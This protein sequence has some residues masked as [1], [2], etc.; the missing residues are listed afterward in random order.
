MRNEGTLFCFACVIH[1]SD[2]CVVGMC[3]RAYNFCTFWL[4]SLCLEW[5]SCSRRVN[6]AAQVVLAA[7]ED[8]EDADE[9]ARIS[10][11]SFACASLLCARD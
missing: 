5:L 10:L 4:H 2:M 6:V 11:W 3:K 8:D 7:A 1:V 9:N